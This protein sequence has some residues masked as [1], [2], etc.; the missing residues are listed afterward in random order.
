MRPEQADLQAPEARKRWLVLREPA[1]DSEEQPGLPAFYAV[2]WQWDVGARWAPVQVVA[3][4]PTG[5]LK[6]HRL[7]QSVPRVMAVALGRL[8]PLAPETMGHAASPSQPVLVKLVM[9]RV[10]PSME[11]LPQAYTQELEK[12]REP[13]VGSEQWRLGRGQVVAVEAWAPEQLE[14]LVAKGKGSAT[15][16]LQPGL[17]KSMIVQAQTSMDSVAQVYAKRP[18]ESKRPEVD[19]VQRQLGLRQGSWS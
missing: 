5:R 1:S 10:Q 19:S 6:S 15:S 9:V 7:V 2:G 3:I 12:P 18:E 13:E 11:S 17:V 14:P 4:G 16:P 8:E